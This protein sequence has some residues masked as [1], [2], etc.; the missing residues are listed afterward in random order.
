MISRSAPAAAAARA[1]SDAIARAPGR[2]HLRQQQRLVADRRGIVPRRID[3]QRPGQPAAVAAG[4]E[5]RPPAARDQLRRQRQGHRRLAGAAGDQVADADHRHAGARRARQPPAQPPRQTVGLAERVQQARRQ[6]VVRPELRRSHRR[7]RGRDRAGGRASPGFPSPAI[8]TSSATARP[9]AA[10]RA[11]RARLASSTLSAA[12]RSAPSATG[13]A[14]PACDQPRGD[15][16]EVVGVGPQQGRAAEPGGLERVLAAMR[17]QRAAD[18]RDGR[19]GGRRGRARPAYRPDRSRS[20]HRA[21]RP[22]SAAPAAG[23][24]A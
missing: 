16:G 13:C 6:R 4:Q 22:G 10:M 3:P 8:A 18:Q 23:R 2:R 19:R 20:R 1:P 11:R 5:V 14:A 17:H 9:C 15:L 24:G 21:A 12:T 7:D